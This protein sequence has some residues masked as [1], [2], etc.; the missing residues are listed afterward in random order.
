MPILQLPEVVWKAS[1]DDIF[2]IFERK[3]G[4]IRRFT[5]CVSRRVITSLQPKILRIAQIRAF[6]TTSSSTGQWSLPMTS[7]KIM[8]FF[9]F[10]LSDLLVKM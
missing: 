5:R 1:F 8:A 10:G 9:T 3:L 4:R 7:G 6:Q 2:N